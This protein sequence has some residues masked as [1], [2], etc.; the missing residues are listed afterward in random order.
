M[1]LL[2]CVNPV[3][4]H[5]LIG[6][7]VLGTPTAAVAIQSI[8]EFWIPTEQRL[9]PLWISISLFIPIL[10]NLFNVRRYGEIE[11]WLTVL[12]IITITGLIVLG[13]LL[14]MEGSD[15]S[16]LLGTDGTEPV[17]CANSSV[18]CLGRPGF[19]CNSLSVTS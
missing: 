12:K 11:Y 13:I 14:P 10:L 6:R 2:V 18:A 5:A 7:Y 17:A 8:M 15:I 9:R 16:P 4:S 19:S 1:G 3:L